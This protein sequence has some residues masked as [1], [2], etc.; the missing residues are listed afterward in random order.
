VPARGGTSFFAADNE[1]PLVGDVDADGRDDLVTFTRGARADV[2]VAWS[3]GSA[4]GPPEVWHTWFAAFNETPLLGDFNGD[5]RADVVTLTRGSTGDVYVATSDGTRF[6]GTG[7]KWQEGFAF[8]DVAVLVGDVNC[9]RR[10]DVVSFGRR[11]IGRVQVAVSLGASFAGGLTWREGLVTRTQVPVVADFNGDGCDDVAALIRGAAPR[12]DVSSP[13]EGRPA[14]P[15]AHRPRGHL[16]FAGEESVPGAGDFTGDG[17]DDLVA[18]T[19]GP[20]ADAFVTVSNGSFFTL[21]VEVERLVRVRPRGADAGRALVM[22]SAYSPAPRRV[23]AEGP[24]AGRAARGCGRI[25]SVVAISSRQWAEA[26]HALDTTLPDGADL[27]AHPQ[28]GRR[29]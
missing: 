22:V 8:G 4:F 14:K 16:A 6:V 10:D 21:D 27:P 29:W 17:R 15:S 11:T 25:A 23:N 13:C 2:L 7:D 1:V 20:A 28:P 26:T 5:G 12:V 19:R 24:G 3:T 18:F 9:D